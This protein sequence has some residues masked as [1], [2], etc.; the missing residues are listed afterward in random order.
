MLQDFNHEI[1]SGY[2][3]KSEQE[4]T[5]TTVIELMEQYL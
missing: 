3:K 4:F 5:E 2:I 1:V